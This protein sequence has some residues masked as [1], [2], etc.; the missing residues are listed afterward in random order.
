M[1]GPRRASRAAVQRPVAG[2]EPMD[3]ESVARVVLVRAVE[4]MLPDRI[5]AETLL[6]A[7][8]A[9]GGPGEGAPWIVRRAEYLVDHALPGH[10]DVLDRLAVATPGPWPFIGAAT[11]LGLVSNYLGP[12]A[13]IHVLWNPIVILI[14][15][16]VLM[17]AVF[18]AFSILHPLGAVAPAA[19][20]AARPR[21]HGPNVTYRPRLV[22]RLV[23]GPALSWLLGL[24]SAAGRARHDAADIEA[25]GRRFAVLWWPV[26]GPAVRLWVRR[27]LHLSAI[28]VVL[29]ATLGMYVR[30]LFFAY[31]V[32]WQS[33][34]VND[35]TSVVAVLGFL[36]GPAAL[37]SGR[38]VPGDEDV[39]RLL[40]AEG[41]PAAAWIHLYAISAVMFVVIP[42]S[43]LALTASRGLNRARRGVELDLDAEYYRDLLERARAISPRELE[44]GVRNAVREECQQIRRRVGDFIAVSLYDERIA[45][46]LWRFR[47]EGGTLRQLEEELA[48]ECAAFGPDLECELARV[49]RDL[50]R[51]L[52]ERVRRLCGGGDRVLMPPAEQV[53]G[54]VGAASSR[55]ATHVAD[56]I[57][58]DL[59]T[60][61]AG[62]ISTSV[63]VVVGTMTGGFGKVLGVALLVGIVKS[64][65]VA[66][67]V[68]AVGALAA[69]SAAFVLGH[70]KLREGAKGL[71]LPAAALKVVLWRGRFERL[72]AD[73]RKRCADAVHESLATPMDQLSCSIAEQLWS[74]LRVIVGEF[75]RPRVGP[76]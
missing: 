44:A 57:G 39:S 38:P 48:N 16:N 49:E 58:A 8:V 26:A 45:P 41:D 5:P 63:A 27:T 42:R 11:V 37:V 52:A 71:P 68:G 72:V 60:M 3:H 61:V 76:G 47:E 46:R 15:W 7:H 14:G 59:A 30:G 43:L 19:T 1:R 6:E 29:G 73:G 54:R 12:S 10:R 32:I 20:T 51:R 18:A 13:R 4:E 40:T 69:T 33:T 67:V 65:P 55:S 62:V 64:G 34:F 23:L 28:G 66:W 36:L 70:A 24:K 22:E 56:R 25:V 53:F 74:R 21:H 35:P 75:Q 31:D 17:Y 9:A 50:E 2:G